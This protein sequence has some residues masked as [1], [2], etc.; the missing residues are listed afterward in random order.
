MPRPDG[1]KNDELRTIKI[2][3]RPLRKADGSV[4]IET[5]FT[6]VICTASIEEGVPPFLKG[7]KSGWLTAE[8][9][10]LPCSANTR[11]ARERAKVSGRTSEIQRIIGRALRRICDLSLIPERTILIDC[12]VIEADGGTRTASISGAF[13]AL[14]Y[15]VEKMKKENSIEKR[16]IRNYAAATSVG[17]VKG[18]LVLDLSYDEDRGAD[19]DMNIVMT[20]ED[21]FIEIQGTGEESTFSED[22]LK[23]LLMLAKHGINQIFQAQKEI[24]PELP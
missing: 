19:V 7:G 8:Y 1:R 9:G 13:L 16:I 15:A 21:R 4:L 2:T 24:F 23:S 14:C 22:D 20:D 11:I 12:D 17:I 10:M 6:K 5:G 3:P 18:E